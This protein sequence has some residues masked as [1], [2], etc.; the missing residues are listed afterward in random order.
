MRILHLMPSFQHPTM[1]G[2]TR[3]Y[4]FLRELSSRH[5]ITLLSLIGANVEIRHCV[6]THLFGKDGV[7][8]RGGHVAIHDNLFEDV[9][10]DGLDLDGGSGEVSR[11]RFIDCRD[12]GID[13]SQTGDVDVFD[14]TILDARGGRIGTDRDLEFLKAKNSLGYTKD[15]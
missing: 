5:R 1:R 2:P 15:R 11:N 7:Y 6:F 8:V 3:H 9:R 12:E 10:K 4:H 13:L 14:N